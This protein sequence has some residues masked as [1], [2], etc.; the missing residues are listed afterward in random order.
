[1]DLRDEIQKIAL[2]WQPAVN[3]IVICPGVVVGG[4]AARPVYQAL[5]RATKSVLPPTSVSLKSRP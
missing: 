2:Q 3:E 1:M 4:D 5:K